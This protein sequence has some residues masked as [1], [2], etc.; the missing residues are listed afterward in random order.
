MTDVGLAKNTGVGVVLNL[1]M[2]CFWFA[3][4]WQNDID[5]YR[6][7]NRSHKVWVVPGGVARHGLAGVVVVQVELLE[8]PHLRLA[9]AGRDRPTLISRDNIHD[10]IYYS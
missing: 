2:N 5:R 9:P 1:D 7:P 8:E 6:L 4:H 3:S 10:I